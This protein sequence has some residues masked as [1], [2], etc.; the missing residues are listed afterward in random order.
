VDR[1][2]P[3]LTCRGWM[4]DVGFRDSYVELLAGPELMVV[5]IK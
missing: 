5:G 2:A 4:T 3:G 1:P